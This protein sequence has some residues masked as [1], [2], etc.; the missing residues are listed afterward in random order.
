MKHIRSRKHSK[1]FQANL[2]GQSI[3]AVTGAIVIPVAVHAQEPAHAPVVTPV[4]TSAPS[5][6]P[7]LKEVK[8]EAQADVPFK[9]ERV[10]SPKATQPLI[11]TPKTVQ[12]IKKEIL[13]EQGAT[14]LMEA[15]RN[16]PGIT[17]QLGENGNTSAGDTFQMRGFST[18]TS[19]FVDGI[20]DLGAVTRDVFN[21]EQVEVVKGPAGSDIGR[22]AA[23]GYINLVSK[24][25]SLEDANSVSASVNTAGNVRGTADLN[26]KV[27]E[28]TAIRLNVMR[29]EG[30]VEGRDVVEENGYAV[31]PSI[32]TGLGTD[33]RFYFFS[34]HVRQNNVPDGGIPTIG[35]SGYYRGVTASGT[36]AT[37]AEQAA[38]ITAGKRVDRENF[39][40]SKSDYEKVDA[41][42]FTGKVEHDLS[43]R[44]RLTSVLRF[45]R[46]SMDRVMTGIASTING[47]NLVD[48][49]DP[50]T[51]TL[52]RSRQRTDQ[53]NE[54]L[55][56]QTNLGLQFETG[57][58]KHDLTTGFEILHERQKSLSFGTASATINGVA[59][60]AIS[61]PVA[62]LYNPNPNDDLGIPYA[63]GA[64]TDGQTDTVSVYVFDTMEVNDKLELTAGVRS[65]RYST[66]TDALTLVT[67]TNASLYPG[68]SVNQLA[69]SMLQDEGTL[70]SW[71]LGAVYKLAGN[72][73]IYAATGTSMTPPGGANF[74][75]SSTTT[76][77]NSPTL[78]PQKTSNMEVGTKW[79]LLNKRLNVSAAVY[80]TEN[81]KQVS[82]DELLNPVQFGKTRVEGVELAAVGQITNFW[83]VSAGLATMETTQLNQWN[84]AHDT[85]T[86][87]V[88]WSP[89]LTATL[90][91][92]YTLDKLT[93]GGGARYVSD[94]K[95]LITE[96]ASVSA[97]TTNMPE[98]PS[99]VVTDLM[100]AYKVNKNVNVRLNVYNVFDELYISTLNNSG[101]R[102]V[103]GDPLS[104]SLGVDVQ[105]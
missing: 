92:S 88:R 71:N 57:S 49:N 8:V 84:D 44:S 61:N 81:D 51:W 4:E 78:E 83:Q 13:Q 16:T 73:T 36:S 28:T 89:E 23:S 43:E 76:N 25:P 75:L 1:G 35:M 11:E 38:A 99:Y 29:Q 105:F 80:R 97:A 56:N 14:S 21:L 31:A 46:T 102:M 6:A 22:G 27:G 32:A 3:A 20:R 63:T 87:G 77:A 18:Q 64:Y 98:I 93:V 72:G 91:T 74:A 9:A 69:P 2:L 70:N 42:M 82:Y 19:T 96:G 10:S 34:Q 85:Q 79:D 104:A 5:S 67:S 47:A 52:G 90:W 45:G 68:Y 94:Q 100:A 37:T 40:G 58:V 65:D 7:V 41:D 95:R 17:M 62:S 66:N 54:I 59:Y 15:L 60:A 103:L 39:Y 86:T 26:R 53:V 48:I 50:S 101:A 33:T 24:L 55:A 12:V 30:G